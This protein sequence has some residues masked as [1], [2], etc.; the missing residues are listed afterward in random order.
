MY[1][2]AQVQVWKLRLRGEITSS[3]PLVGEVGARV[4]RDA[5]PVLS[6]AAPEMGHCLQKELSGVALASE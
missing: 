3:S 4:G 1:C 2:A 5:S 6:K